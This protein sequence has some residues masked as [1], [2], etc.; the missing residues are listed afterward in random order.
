MFRLGWT[1]PESLLEHYPN[2]YP[3]WEYYHI[4]KRVLGVMH[5]PPAY[6]PMYTLTT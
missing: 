3:Y 1:V 5:T 4:E 6:T 2:P